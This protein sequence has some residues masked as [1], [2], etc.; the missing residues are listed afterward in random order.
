MNKKCCV[1]KILALI[2]PS[3]SKGQVSLVQGEKKIQKNHLIHKLSSIQ[4][5]YTL[6]DRM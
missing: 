6:I 5:C 1:I 4:D 2:I 3:N